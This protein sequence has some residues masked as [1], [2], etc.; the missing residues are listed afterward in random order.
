MG[1]AMQ[2][3]RGRTLVVACGMLFVLGVTTAVLG[4]VLPELAARTGSPLA[5]LGAV[6]TA[7]FLGALATQTVAGPLADRVGE[8]PVLLG[9][10][11]VTT[12]GVIGVALSP[13]LP[14]TLVCAFVLG[15]GH[16][17]VDVSTNVLVARTFADRP[18]TALNVLHV[19]FGGGAVVG[20]A[21]AGL[22][23]E[24]LGTGLPALY[25]GLVPLIVLAPLVPPI[26][27]PKRTG[28]AQTTNGGQAGLYR[29]PLV[30]ALGF[31]LLLYVGTE[32]GMSGWAT[33][34]MQRA[35]G[36]SLAVGA[37][38][39]SAFWLALSAGRMVGATLGAR[40]PSGRVLWL[41]LAAASAGGLLLVAVQGQAAA[42]VF[43]IALIGFGFGPIFPTTVATA[44][45][46]FPDA[47]GR[48]T[49]LIV[50]FGSLGGM[51]LPWIQ[52][53][54]LDGQGPAAIALFVAVC[55]L[56]MLA[57]HAAIGAGVARRQTAAG[58]NV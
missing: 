52:G 4:P 2:Q 26:P 27:R 39:T 53:Q 21:M 15:L 8:R 55:I 29:S 12:L 32:M 23:I 19:F 49:S 51:L 13:A 56:A 34:Y 24:G 18:V 45:A 57:L 41:S 17:A 40:M 20:P 3:N 36:V 30:W 28:N 42:S 6:F 50:A 16:G 46:R 25:A 10:L 5:A 35:A 38:V 54:L 11:A 1:D 47:P 37:W 7:L 22:A 44:T 31:L 43:A 33:A 48:A 14:L 58:G 9:G